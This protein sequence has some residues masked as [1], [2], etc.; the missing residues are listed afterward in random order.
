MQELGM[1]VNTVHAGTGGWT[2]FMQELVG[3]VNIVHAGTG[4][5]CVNIVH[6]GTRGGGEQCS[7]RNM[8]ESGGGNE[9]VLEMGGGGGGTELKAIAM[10]ATGG[11]KPDF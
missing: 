10:G 4:W 1:G 11:Q 3:Y 5:V 8:L 6:A 9:R 2:L 7:C